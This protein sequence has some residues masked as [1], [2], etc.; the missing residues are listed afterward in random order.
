MKLEAKRE[1]LEAMADKLRARSESAYKS[2][3]VIGNAIP[4]GQPILV[5]HHS[6][7]RHRRHIARI[8]SLMRRCI[9]EQKQADEC[10]RRA[11]AVGTG[12]ISREDPEAVVKLKA[13]IEGAEKLRDE[14]KA[15]N[16]AFKKSPTVE[17]IPEHLRAKALANF[18]FSW[19]KDRPFPPFEITNLGANIRRMKARVEELSREP[20]KFDD[21]EGEGF[22]I[23]NDADEFRVCVKFEKRASSDVCRTLKTYGFRWS[24]TRSVWMRQ[25]TASGFYAAK[26]VAPLIASGRVSG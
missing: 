19:C 26:M 4:F 17:A 9:D 16:K 21:I 23:W 6:E 13:Q 18:K 22:R 1:R 8:D 14:M 12:G 25:N 5:G 15:A 20:Q 24:P 3:G 7:K 11:A 2:A 10:E